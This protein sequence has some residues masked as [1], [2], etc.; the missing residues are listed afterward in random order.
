MRQPPAA[1]SGVFLHRGTTLGK[2]RQAAGGPPLSLM[3][4]AYIRLRGCYRQLNLGGWFVVFQD[5][6]ETG[7]SVS[8]ARLIQL[9]V[10]T[11]ACGGR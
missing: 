6:L 7:K 5:G 2:A 9:W 11:P 4:R 3:T 10:V 1:L 8:W